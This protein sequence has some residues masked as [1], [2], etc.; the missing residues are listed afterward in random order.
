VNWTDSSILD[1]FFFRHYLFP[2]PGR[3]NKKPKTP[4]LRLEHAAEKVKTDLGP[5]AKRLKFKIYTRQAG[6]GLVELI[7]GNS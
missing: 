7:C 6:G 1:L 4:K 5:L 3:G 2:T